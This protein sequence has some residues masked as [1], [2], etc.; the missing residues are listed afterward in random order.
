MPSSSQIV[1]VHILRST[2]G[3]L[4]DSTPILGTSTCLRDAAEAVHIILFSLQQSHPQTAR[5]N[6]SPCLRPEMHMS[7]VVDIYVCTVHRES[8]RQA[9]QG[10][11]H[12]QCSLCVLSQLK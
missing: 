4:P 7:T 2:A 9:W 10:Q 5:R 12:M 3:L 11:G 6:R 8:L 1:N